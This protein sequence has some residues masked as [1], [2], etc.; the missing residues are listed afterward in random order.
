MQTGNIYYLIPDVFTE[1]FHFVTLLR[2]L[3]KGMAIPY[4]KDCITGRN[5]PIGGIK[6]HY[7]HPLI[8]NEIGYHASP[9][10]MGRYDGDFWNYPIKPLHIKNVGFNLAHNDIVVSTEF[11][12]Y[13]GL[14]FKNC[15]RIIFVQNWINIARQL[16]PEDKTKSYLDLGYDQVLTCSQYIANILSTTMGI[17]SNIV[18]NGVDQNIFYESAS[19]RNKNQILCLP[20]KNKTDLEKIKAIVLAQKPEVTFV[21]ADN[22]TQEQIALEYRKSDIFLATGYPEGFGLPPLE[23]MF[24]GC[25]VVGFTG[26]GA[27]EFMQHEKTAL[28]A[29]DGDC[30]AAANSLLKVLNEPQLKESL[31]SNGLRISQNYTL[32]KMK[33]SLTK[34]YSTPSTV[35]GI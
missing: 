27:L 31:R 25:A 19:S 13:E 14:R 9:L 6:M 4:I 30:K 12:P 33:T 7:L 10:V 22:L 26:G 29:K 2:R 17:E 5:R 24:S 1:H 18:P 32:Q 21:E 16:K 35:E 15:R 11:F 23:A 3:K 28:V 20:R 8:L 34:F